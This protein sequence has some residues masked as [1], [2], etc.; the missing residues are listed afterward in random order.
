MRRYLLLVVSAVLL[1]V[2]LAGV[3]ATN[4]IPTQIKKEAALV[5]YEHEGTFD[6]LI[7]LKPSALYGSAPTSSYPAAIVGSLDFT[8]SYNPVES[9]PES[10]SVDAILENPGIWQKKIVLVPETTTTGNF[11]CSFSLDIDQIIKLFDDTESELNIPSSERY[12]SIEAD[13][14]NSSGVFTQSLPITLTDTVIDVSNG[15]SYRQ[16]SGTGS[17]QY[18]VNLKPNSTFDTSTLEPPQAADNAS[19]TLG[20]GQTVFSQLVDGM[21]ASFQYAFNADKP[22]ANVTTD[23]QI[24]ASID[25]PNFWSRTFPVLS[26]SKGGN[27]TID[28]PIDLAGYLNLLDAFNAETGV[29]SASSEVA[30]DAQVHTVGQSQF[31]PIDET[32]SQEMKGTI[33]GGVI[34]WQTELTKTQTG[35]TQ[36]VTL[37]SNASKYLGLSV[38]RAKTLTR[39]L[40]AIFLLFLVVSLILYFRSRRALRPPINME[41]LQIQK[42]YRQRIAEATSQTPSENGALINLGSMESLISVADELGKPI[43]HQAPGTPEGRHAYYILDG[44]IR[45]QYLPSSGI[46]EQNND[47]EETG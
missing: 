11:T 41:A 20:P 43:I 42:K 24:T 19:P 5:N 47:M 31:G 46:L 12:L 22:V 4:G 37:V 10:A 6:Y 1:F 30:V 18:I 26:V 44:T 45:Y 7:H 29:A 28:F 9:V 16:F 33:T 17:F 14:T 38:N 2:S 39:A 23:T 27:F 3:L 32:Y 40:T 34:E 35:A 8:F 36:Q 25:V 21:D 13:V 15:L